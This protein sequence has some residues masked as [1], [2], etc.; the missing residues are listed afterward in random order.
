MIIK[1]IAKWTTTNVSYYAA[2]DEGEYVLSEEAAPKGYVLN[3]DKVYF[4]VD[5]A[6]NLYIKDANGNYNVAGGIIFYNSPEIIVVPATGLSSTLTYIIGSLVLGFG[7]IM[8]Y[9]NEKK[10]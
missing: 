10:C 3:T 2:L 6:G 7:A 1:V 9:R 5:A 8:L 4:K